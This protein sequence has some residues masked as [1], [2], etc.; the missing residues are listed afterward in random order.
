MNPRKLYNSLALSYD[1]R[2]TNPTTGVLR[3]REEHILTLAQGRILDMGC[4]T[5]FYL[6]PFKDIIGLEISENM[7]KIALDKKKPLVQGMCES[8]P[9]KDNSF[10]TVLCMFAVLNFCNSE[11]TLKEIK[12]ILKPKGRVIMSLASIYDQDL[13]FLEKLTR[14]LPK[15]KD[16]TIEKEKTTIRLYTK[17]EILNMFRNLGFTLERFDS[18]FILQK[19]RWGNFKP[20]SPLEKLK[21]KLES[22]MPKKYGCVYFFSFRL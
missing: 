11:K 1:T 13:T 12:R 22:F 18:C 7:L 20:Y 17:S 19:P 5:G 3:K 21:L 6:P 9:L 15:T 4:G 10:N 2:N 14:D 16:F 8:L